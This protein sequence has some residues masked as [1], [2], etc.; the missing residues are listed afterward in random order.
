MRFYTKEEIK[1]PKRTKNEPLKKYVSRCVP[2][3]RGEH[4]EES[5]ERSVA[6]CYGM[7]RKTKKKK[8]G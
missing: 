3:R 1:M 6:A 8:K 4:P 2:V 5:Q 7:G